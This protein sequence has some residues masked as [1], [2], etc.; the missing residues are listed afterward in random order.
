MST[1]YYLRTNICEC[2][3]RYDEQHIGK[4]S[5]GSKFVFYLP[6]EYEV[7]RDYFVEVCRIVLTGN[8][9]I[10]DEYGKEVTIRELKDVVKSE[11]KDEGRLVD[12]LGQPYHREWFC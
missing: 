11:D 6:E 8:G 9:K 5:Y 1:N 10:F 4:K 2:C 7:C 3:N 12:S